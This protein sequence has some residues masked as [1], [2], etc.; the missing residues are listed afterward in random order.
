MRLFDKADYSFIQKARGAAFFSGTLILIGVSSMVLN[1]QS[2][3]SWQN[4]GVDF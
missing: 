4:Y 3:G 1:V 2:I